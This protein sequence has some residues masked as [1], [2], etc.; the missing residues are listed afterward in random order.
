MIKNCEI[1]KI[2][3]VMKGFATKAEIDEEIKELMEDGYSL[4][5][6]IKVLIANIDNWAKWCNDD[7]KIV[8]DRIN[9]LGIEVE[10]RYCTKN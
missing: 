6:A 9:K 1:R 3:K 5:D 2:Y 4:D 8:W 10:R 7:A